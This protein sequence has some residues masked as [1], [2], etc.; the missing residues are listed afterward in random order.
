MNINTK[1]SSSA[2]RS[3][4]GPNDP[5]RLQRVQVQVA[6]QKVKNVLLGATTFFVGFNALAAARPSETGEKQS[7]L[8]LF[9]LW[10]LCLLASPK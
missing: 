4:L 3:T 10:I 8:Q 6:E 9:L 1:K 2:S 7:F 5:L